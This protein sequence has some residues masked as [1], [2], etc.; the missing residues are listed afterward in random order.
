ML[1]TDVLVV[2]DQDLVR[3]G[4]AA[5]IDAA[6]GLRVVG[7][8]AT[9]H[10]AVAQSAALRPDVVTIDICIS[11]LSG[12][13][14]TAQIRAQ[15]GGPVRPCV[16]ILTTLD[17][18]EYVCAALR[19]GASGFVLKETSPDRLLAAIHTVAAGDSLFAPTVV[20]RMVAAYTR[21]TDSLAALSADLE[22]LTPRELDVLRYVG[23]GLAN[24]DIAKRLVVSESTVKTHLNRTLAK[25]QISSRAQAVVLAYETGL[26]TPNWSPSRRLGSR[27][28][29]Q[30]GLVDLDRSA[31]DL[32][33]WGRS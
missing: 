13:A 12:A 25:L 26:V 31:G 24:A 3:A 1:M 23:R 11:G 16:L 27:V 28:P 19:A 33:G 29:P 21:M 20:R 10:D 22:T 6:P 14:A 4:L 30:R 17:L 5:L 7:R 32:T 8:A 15:A 9:G 18:D 2:D